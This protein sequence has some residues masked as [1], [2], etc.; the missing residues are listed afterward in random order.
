MRAVVGATYVLAVG[1]LVPQKG[2]DVLIERS[3]RRAHIAGLLIAGE[4]FERERLMKRVERAGAGRTSKASRPVALDRL[5]R[6]GFFSAPC[7]RVPIKRQ[8]V[9]DRLARSNGRGRPGSRRRS[10]RDPGAGGRR[11]ERATRRAGGRPVSSPQRS[12]DSRGTRTC[13]TASLPVDEAQHDGSAGR[14]SRGGYPSSRGGRARTVRVAI[15]SGP[16]SPQPMGLELAERRLLDAL[17]K[18]PRD[19]V[20]DVRVVGRRRALHHARSFVRAGSCSGRRL[21]SLASAG[22]DLVHLIGLDLP[23]PRRKPFV[24][25]VHDLA[26]LHFD[27]EVRFRPGWTRRSAAPGS[28][29][30][31]RGSPL[32][33][34]RS[35]SVSRPRGSECSARLLHS[36]PAAPSR[37]RGATFKNSGSF[38]RSSSGTAGTQSERTCRSC[39]KRGH[40][41]RKHA[42]AGRSAAASTSPGA[43]RR[44]LARARRRP[45]LRTPRALGTPAPHRSGPCLPVHI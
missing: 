22:A 21:P 8:T 1:R 11:G 18:A 44:P 37:F 38:R 36:T 41:C 26:P 39:W 25:T 35:T 14:T 30:R 45:G 16:R 28:C 17:R 32:A 4:G 23:P 42:R 33:N 5:T 7:L 13:G 29:R 12:R 6:A 10:G 9:R 20:V 31:R 15:V 27:D 19:I 24:A 2:F 40:R 34:S 43:G 3:R